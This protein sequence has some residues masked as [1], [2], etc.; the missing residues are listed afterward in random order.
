MLRKICIVGVQFVV[1]LSTLVGE[2]LL[3]GTD[4]RFGGGLAQLHVVCS[5]CSWRHTLNGS[6]Q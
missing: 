6:G 3:G 4:G 5:L 2:K 1:E